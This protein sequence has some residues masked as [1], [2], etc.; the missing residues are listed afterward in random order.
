[1]EPSLDVKKYLCYC[2][3]R[4]S[5]A[6]HHVSQKNELEWSKFHSGVNRSEPNEDHRGGVVLS[7]HW[8]I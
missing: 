8:V 2:G 6:I 1:M 4:C 5:T 3:L 7:K